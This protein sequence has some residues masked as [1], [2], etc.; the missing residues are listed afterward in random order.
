[1]ALKEIELD[2]SIH[3]ILYIL[4]CP[5]HCFLCCPYR[6]TLTLTD[7][8]VLR[9][10]DSLC[11]QLESER[12]YADLGT[13]R[14]SFCCC[15][16]CVDASNLGGTIVLGCGFDEQRAGRLV[17]TLRDRI[18]AQSPAAQVERFGIVLSK[19]NQINEKLAAIERCLQDKCCLDSK[20]MER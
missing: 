19:T 11:G 7:T 10:D 20:E 16:T 4:S 18:D 14:Q 1:M 15:S 8:V 3:P 9:R 6:T 12:Y 5:I 17:E 13:V 2:A